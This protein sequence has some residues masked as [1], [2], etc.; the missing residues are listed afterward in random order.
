MHLVGKWE[1]YLNLENNCLIDL[2][3]RKYKHAYY[4]QSWV[5]HLLWSFYKIE[6]KG[7]SKN[8]TY[9]FCRD[10]YVFFNPLPE[11]F[12]YSSLEGLLKLYIEASQKRVCFFPQSSLIYLEKLKKSKKAGQAKEKEA[13]SIVSQNLVW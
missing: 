7:S 11:A 10:K 8:D 12:V 6:N 4:F 9:F 13:L 3:Y 5:S 2:K 1:P